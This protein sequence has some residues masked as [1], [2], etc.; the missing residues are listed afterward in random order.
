[1]RCAALRKCS[2]RTAKILIE[3]GHRALSSNDLVSYLVSGTYPADLETA[4]AGRS[5]SRA[6]GEMGSRTVQSDRAK[7]FEGRRAAA[8]ARCVHVHGHRAAGG[9][10]EEIVREGGGR[11]DT[12]RHTDT[13]VHGREGGL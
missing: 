7:G 5:F 2:A 4:R 3:G 9:R 1:M 12:H 13:S 6:S 8:A 10:D 11:S